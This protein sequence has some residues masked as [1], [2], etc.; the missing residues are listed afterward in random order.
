MT[1]NEKL[2]EQEIENLLKK[3]GPL[4]QPP[5]EM[6]LRVRS[7]VHKQWRKETAARQKNRFR[8]SAAAAVIVAAGAIA[9][10][11]SGQSPDNDAYIARVDGR[12]ETM[13]A[14]SEDG[15]WNPVSSDRLLDG[16]EIKAQEPSSITFAGGMNVRLNRDT[17][18]TLLSSNSVQLNSGSLYLDSYDRPE[19]EAFQVLTAFGLAEDIGTQFMVS[20]DD[21]G[22]SVQVR[23]GE[24]NVS[25]SGQQVTLAQGDKVSISTDDDISKATVAPYDASWRW[26]ESSRPVYQLEGRKLGEYLDWV[27]RETGKSVEYNSQEASEM[28]TATTLHGSIDH[29]SAS[30]SLAYVLRS[31]RFQVIDETQNVILI[32]LIP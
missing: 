6:A 1:N 31:T 15:K 27:A 16:M 21:G 20:T 2:T 10:F 7:K 12:T 4:Q 29:L 17:D 5:E 24:V 30:D 11:Q 9:L 19:A 8:M 14:L 26:T 32:D 3:V 28:A 13:M 22:W 25:D 23:E 18:I